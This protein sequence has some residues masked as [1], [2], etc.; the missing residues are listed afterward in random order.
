MT[1]LFLLA[2]QRNVSNSIIIPHWF[3]FEGPQ[4]WG[5]NIKR[6]S[7]NRLKNKDWG[8]EQTTD[9]RKHLYPPQN[10]AKSRCYGFNTGHH[11]HSKHLLT[12]GANGVME[13]LC[14]DGGRPL[15][16]VISKGTAH[17]P[18]FSS[19]LR[20]WPS[21][22]LSRTELMQALRLYMSELLSWRN[23]FPK[24]SV[25]SAVHHADVMLTPS[26]WRTIFWWNNLMK[27]LEK[28]GASWPFVCGWG[29]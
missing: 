13:S 23:A 4:K 28:K 1:K 18:I 5:E 9:D 17:L 25:A 15:G 2:E 19:V 20:R 3:Q 21:A 7:T 10:K 11:P 26:T 14:G 22:T 12:R 6:F 8:Q 16:P 24:K 29:T 27:S